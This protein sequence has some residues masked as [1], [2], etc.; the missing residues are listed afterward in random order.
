MSANNQ[1]LNKKY[2]SAAKRVGDI[3]RQLEVVSKRR[4]AELLKQSKAHRLNA[5][6][7]A[8]LLPN[9]KNEL[10]KSILSNGYGPKWQVFAWRPAAL[11]RRGTQSVSDLLRG[12]YVAT[13]VVPVG[14]VLFAAWSN[15]GQL[16]VI[17]SPMTV[18][19]QMP[20]GEILRRTV[21]AGES[22][23]LLKRYDGSFVV[24]KWYAQ[25]GYATAKVNVANDR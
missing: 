1:A 18:D 19:W 15:T 14:Y 8:D 16:I 9:E 10:R 22:L 2:R 3:E 25:E 17:S 4:L 12:F 13:I 7:D 11:L 20:N 21:P 6:D 24:R 5:F 23:V